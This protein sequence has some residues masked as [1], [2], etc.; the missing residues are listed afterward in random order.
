MSD[1][2]E[3]TNQQVEIEKRTWEMKSW[4]SRIYRSNK[5]IGNEA[6]VDNFVDRYLAF[7]K[8][9]KVRFKGT[10]HEYITH[11]IARQS[12]PEVALTK[13]DFPDEYSLYEFVKNYVEEND[14]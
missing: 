3:K 7:I 5:K 11:H 1:N 4:I 2:Q 8:T 9:V 6:I 14:P 10:Y 13:F 12:T